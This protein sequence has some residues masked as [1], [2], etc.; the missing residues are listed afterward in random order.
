MPAWS[1]AE[2]PRSSGGQR[3]EMV[4]SKIKGNRLIVFAVVAALL[5]VRIALQGRAPTRSDVNRSDASR[6]SQDIKPPSSSSSSF[7]SVSKCAESWRASTDVRPG[8][9]RRYFMPGGYRTNE[10]R[11]FNDLTDMRLVWQPDVYNIAAHLAAATEDS[12]IIDVGGGTGL[13]AA[14]IYNSSSHKFVE[15][16]FGKNLQVNKNG[17]MQTERY[18]RTNG[19]GAYHYEWD[20]SKERFPEIGVEKFRGATIV[21][22]DVIEHLENPDGLVDSLLALMNGCGANHLLISTIDR[23]TGPEG[24]PPNVHHIRE[25]SLDELKQYLTSRGAAIA[26]CGLTYSNNHDKHQNSEKRTS[27]CFI[28]RTRESLPDVNFVYNYFQYA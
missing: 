4:L 26:E 20:I 16:D 7:S 11:Y 15:L 1:A 12:W 13:K 2:F 23:R 17:F 19:A 8:A 3:L 25:W 21:S 27:L 10:I 14:K 9:E 24:P 18:K 22:A 28:S 6:R 5:C